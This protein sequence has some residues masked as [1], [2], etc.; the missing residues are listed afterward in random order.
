MF[1]GLKLFV[2]AHKA[3]T[4][5]SLLAGTNSFLTIFL[6][7]NGVVLF[8]ETGLN[9]S[10]QRVDYLPLSK[11]LKPSRVNSDVGLGKLLKTCQEAYNTVKESR[12]GT[13]LQCG[14][15]M[16]AASGE[17]RWCLANERGITEDWSQTQVL[18]GCRQ[19]L[20]WGFLLPYLDNCFSPFVMKLRF[21][22]LC[23]H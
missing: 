9:P 23:M 15:R 19:N 1:Q 13:W 18:L 22:Y 4:Q 12:D 5:S 21:Q 8:W 2:P 6:W 17:W 14:V 3:L 7:W 11:R 16:L 20:L 10:W